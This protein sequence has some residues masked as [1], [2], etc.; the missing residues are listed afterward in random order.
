MGGM[1]L[2]G[3][4]TGLTSPR[5]RALIHNSP[6]WPPFIHILTPPWLRSM[7]FSPPPP[8]PVSQW[9]PLWW[10]VQLAAFIYLLGSGDS[11]ESAAAAFLW[12]VFSLTL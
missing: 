3:K 7:E 5:E 8:L 1:I 11:E 6:P 4:E 10:D 9:T 2:G 12:T